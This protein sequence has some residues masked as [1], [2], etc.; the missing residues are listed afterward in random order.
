VFFAAVEQNPFG[1][2]SLSGVDVSIMPML[3]LYSSGVGFI[4]C[5][6]SS[7]GQFG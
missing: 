3:R 7:I 1:G 4:Y 5:I 2:G 6:F